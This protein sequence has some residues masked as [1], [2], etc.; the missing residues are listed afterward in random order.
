MKD[1]LKI[2]FKIGIKIS[3]LSY[4]FIE[5]PQDHWIGSSYFDVFWFFNAM[6]MCAFVSMCVFVCG[7]ECVTYNLYESFC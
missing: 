1:I 5:N 2:A 7:K 3:T 6:G 4:A